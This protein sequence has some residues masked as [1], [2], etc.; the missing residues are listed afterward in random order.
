MSVFT[1]PKVPSALAKKATWWSPEDVA[2]MKRGSLIFAFSW[3]VCGLSQNPLHSWLLRISKKRS[4]WKSLSLYSALCKTVQWQEDFIWTKIAQSFLFM[5]F[6]NKVAQQAYAAIM[7]LCRQSSLLS[8]SNI[9][10]E[11]LGDL[12]VLTISDFYC[13]PHL[14]SEITALDWTL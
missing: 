9:S 14:F 10:K 3:N 2:T 7:Q 4:F 8:L 12:S 13:W 1:L 5:A 6:W 11:G